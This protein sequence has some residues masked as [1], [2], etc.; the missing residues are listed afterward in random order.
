VHSFWRRLIHPDGEDARALHN[1]ALAL[2]LAFLP[3][4]QTVVSFPYPSGFILSNIGSILAIIAIALVY[5]NYAPEINSFM[6]KLVGIAFASVLLIVAVAGS[7]DVYFANVLAYELGASDATKSLYLNEIVFRWLL[8]ILAASA[9]VL[10]LFPLFF[11]AFWCSRSRI[12][13][14]A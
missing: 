5:F 2:S 9:F 4:I 7:I 14:K 12:F 8:L 10:L 3:A 1:L 11:A 6:A 13:C